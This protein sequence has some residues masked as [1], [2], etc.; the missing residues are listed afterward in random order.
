MVS[1]V[2]RP[3]MLQA[4]RLAAITI[5]LGLNAMWPTRATAGSCMTCVGSGECQAADDHTP[6]W[7]CC[8]SDP[9]GGC[10]VCCGSNCDTYCGGYED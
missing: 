10:N 5:V 9:T 3:V 7:A 6:R 1:V 8:Q 2:S 4:L